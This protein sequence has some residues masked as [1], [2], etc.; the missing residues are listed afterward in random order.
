MQVRARRQPTLET[1]KLLQGILSSDIARE[2][3][4]RLQEG[5][6]KVMILSRR[7]R[8][9][10]ASHPCFGGKRRLLRNLRF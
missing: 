1:V 2:E 3:L 9:S 8:D 4:I 6:Q 7:E 10:K 5:K